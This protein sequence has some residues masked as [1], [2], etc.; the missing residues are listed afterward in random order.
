MSTREDAVFARVVLHNKLLS[1]AQVNQ[2]MQEVKAAAEEGEVVSLSEVVLTKKLLSR[3][4]AYAVAWAVQYSMMKSQDR[5]Y[6]QA[7][8]ERG[9]VGKE[10]VEAA[11]ATQRHLR[12]SKR[13]NVSIHDILISEKVIDQ[14][15]ADAIWRE[16]KPHGDVE[17]EDVAEAEEE[18]AAAP[19]GPEEIRAG[20]CRGTMEMIAVSRR[21]NATC[22]HLTGALDADS[23]HE[24]QDIIDEVLQREGDE[25]K[26]LILD[27]GGLN[28]MSS[29]GVGV[30]LSANKTA[31]EKDGAFE[32]AD[33]SED[34]RQIL[35]LMGL[36]EVLNLHTMTQAMKAIARA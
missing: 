10:D 25:G 4:Q 17:K 35:D 16:M 36:G 12:A 34:V 21:R 28:Y 1:K 2:C 8:I 33:P 19:G 24:L 13:Q 30:L 29:A 31:Q 18:K 14:R 9:L 7:L 20:S 22:M 15:D 5:L 23:F 3:K 32:I 27:L 6:A 11:F 26:Y